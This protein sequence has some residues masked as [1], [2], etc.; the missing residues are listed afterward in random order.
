MEGYTIK[1]CNLLLMLRLPCDQYRGRHSRNSAFRAD[2]SS[3]KHRA[4]KYAETTLRRVLSLDATDGR[5]YVSLGKLLVQQR[6]FD[7]ARKLYDDGTT[8]T[9]GPVK[10]QND[11]QA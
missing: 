5:A 4:Q 11:F 3:G 9:G 6:R 10:N 1:C 7:E 8:A 2:D